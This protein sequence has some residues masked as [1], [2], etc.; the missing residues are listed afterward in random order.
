MLKMDKHQRFKCVLDSYELEFLQPDINED[1]CFT[2]DLDVGV[3]VPWIFR[4]EGKRSECGW[5][6]RLTVDLNKEW[7]LPLN[8]SI[9]NIDIMM[10]STIDGISVQSQGS[11]LVGRRP[12][13]EGSQL[14]MLRTIERKTITNAGNDD[15]SD[16]PTL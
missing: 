7:P 1:T 8:V 11:T 6:F 12:Q 16:V 14:D 13:H 3:H 5:T 4:C 2:P 9:F 10:K 15:G